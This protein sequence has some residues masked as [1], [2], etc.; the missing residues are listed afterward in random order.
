MCTIVVFT[1]D[2]GGTRML[3]V[4]INDQRI[5]FIFQSILFVYSFFRNHCNLFYV[6]EKKNVKNERFVF[7]FLFPVLSCF[8]LRLLCSITFT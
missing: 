3:S 8:M 4:L 1:I 7:L 6:F 2:A 5:Q